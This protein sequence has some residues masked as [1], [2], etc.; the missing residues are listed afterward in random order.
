MDSPPN[1]PPPP[2]NPE[3]RGGGLYK[4]YNEP[5][6]PLTPTIRLETPPPSEVEY[7]QFMDQPQPELESTY[8]TKYK[9]SLTFN[10]F[11]ALLFVVVLVILILL[12]I[13]LLSLTSID[14]P[15]AT[16]FESI[17]YGPKPNLPANPLIWDPQLSAY[18]IASTM[19]A[20]NLKLG[21][22]PQFPNYVQNFQMLPKDFGYVAQIA[23]PEFGFS[24]VVAFRGTLTKVDY[25]TDFS[26]NQVPV[27][28]N[29][30]LLV[31]RGFLDVARLVLPDV[32]SALAS[33]RSVL[34]TGHSLGAA[35]AEI[36]ATL[37]AQTEVIRPTYL[38]VSGRPRV[39]NLAWD[40]LVSQFVN[41]MVLNNEADDV[42]QVPAPTMP[43]RG[44]SQKFSYLNPPYQN[45]IVFWYQTLNVGHNH[46][47]RTYLSQIDPDYPAP[48]KA[49]E[50]V[51]PPTQLLIDSS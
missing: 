28:N 3:F 32:F 13:W 4:N 44:T 51:L 41:R 1:Y 12:I 24:H 35:V 27:E 2:I 17:P 16:P 48:F 5:S 25:Q 9:W 29:P 30:N 26:W 21:Q 10:I 40:D 47:L 38:Y 15:P 33:A 50:E 39:G 14:I 7:S 20:V 37:W 43:G 49:Q 46:D 11:L 23:D 45:T 6:A 8:Q 34:F 36:V 42:P 19:S 18:G 22:N 31:H